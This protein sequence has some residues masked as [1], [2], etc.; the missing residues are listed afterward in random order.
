MFLARVIEPEN[1]FKRKWFSYS[2]SDHING[3]GLVQFH[4]SSLDQHHTIGEIDFNMFISQ[5]CLEVLV[6][7]IELHL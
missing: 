4:F 6:I 2:I 5:N 7:S 3:V 1:V